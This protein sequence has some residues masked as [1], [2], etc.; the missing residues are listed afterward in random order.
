MPHGVAVEGR[1]AR[2]RLIHA[3]RLVREAAS[4]LMCSRKGHMLNFFQQWAYKRPTSK[5]Q[6]SGTHGVLTCNQHN[7]DVTAGLQVLM[8]CGSL[9]SLN[10]DAH[11]DRLTAIQSRGVAFEGRVM[12]PRHSHASQL[13][14]EAATR[15]MRPRK[16]HTLKHFQHWAYKRPT[17]KQTAYSSFTVQPVH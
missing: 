1:A 2:H 4:R 10:N 13:M 12:T 11:S 17:W 5:G 15:L 9:V 6:Q 8:Q 7:V 3:S 16:G 14:R